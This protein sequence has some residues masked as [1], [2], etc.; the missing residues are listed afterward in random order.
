[1]KV[2]KWKDEKKKSFFNR[3]L[4]EKVKKTLHFIT[5]IF[6][7]AIL[8]I[9]VI[10]GTMM[11]IYFIDIKIN[12]AKGTYTAPIYGAYIIISESMVPTIQVQDAI[13]IKRVEGE[14]IKV[15]DIIT[16]TSTDTRFPGVTITHRVVEITKD[17]KGKYLFRTKGDHNNT[18]DFTLIDEDHVN[19]KVV[20][21]IPKIGYIQY[22][23]TQ[24]YGWIIAVVIPCLGI[25][26]YDIMKL[27][28]VIKNNIKPK[29]KIVSK[30]G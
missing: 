2:E 29:K 9:L 12:V 18:A 5:S 6:M 4:F 24:S 1:M 17:E 22:F 7:Y 27:C 28:K 14:D 30:K 13:V 25:V 20:L 11:L 3:E 19:G 21:K 15:G 23:L 26:I 16:F 10:A 8:G